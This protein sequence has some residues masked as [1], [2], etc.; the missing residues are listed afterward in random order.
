[1]AASVKLCRLPTAHIRRLHRGKCTAFAGPRS[2]FRRASERAACGGPL[3]EAGSLCDAAYFARSKRRIFSA[4]FGTGATAEREPEW[5]PSQ[6]RQRDAT[7]SESDCIDQI[8]RGEDFTAVHDPHGCNAVLRNMATEGD[9]SAGA[10]L[11]SLLQQSSQSYPQVQWKP[12]NRNVGAPGSVFDARP[13]AIGRVDAAKPDRP[14]IDNAHRPH[15]WILAAYRRSRVRACPAG[16]GLPA[17]CDA[18]GCSR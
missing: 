13:L 12:L 18:A 7:V 10:G 3:L 9:V 11:A 14:S 8:S 2:R 15:L 17:A 5:L 6:G 4:N 16:C 1:M